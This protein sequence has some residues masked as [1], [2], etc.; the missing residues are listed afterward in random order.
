MRECDFVIKTSSAAIQ[1]LENENLP[2]VGGP[3]AVVAIGE[4]AAD[5]AA[6]VVVVPASRCAEA[7]EALALEGGLIGQA[8]RFHRG[9]QGG[10]LAI[11]GKRDRLRPPHQLAPLA[12][13]AGFLK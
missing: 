2:V 3:L 4:R 12:L 13:L 11:I 1:C 9:G 6:V 10:D 7:F 5:Q 8:A